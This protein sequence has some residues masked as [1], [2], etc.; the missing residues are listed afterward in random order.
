MKTPFRRLRFP[1]DRCR[2]FSQWDWATGC[3]AAG[4]RLGTNW[5]F[6]VEQ[7]ARRGRTRRSP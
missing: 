4:R 1:P 7:S 3:W 5:P 2:A 6:I